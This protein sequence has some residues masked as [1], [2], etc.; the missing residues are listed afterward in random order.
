VPRLTRKALSE[1]LVDDE[2]LPPVAPVGADEE[3]P[4]EADTSASTA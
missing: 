3:P 2:T 1:I 4:T